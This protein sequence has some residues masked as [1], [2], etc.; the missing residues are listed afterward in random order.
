VGCAT[1]ANND[2][3]ADYYT[4]THSQDAGKDGIPQACK[5]AAG[6]FTAKAFGSACKQGD[7]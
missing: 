5:N 4:Q 1:G 6:F 2:C 3:Q 7:T